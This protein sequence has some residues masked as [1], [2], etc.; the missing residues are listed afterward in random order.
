MYPNL[1]PLTVIATSVFCVIVKVYGVPEQYP[2][3]GSQYVP[4]LSSGQVDE[5]GLR[6]N[7]IPPPVLSP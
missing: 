3:A 4:V 6:S 2:S 7:V 5:L 1:L